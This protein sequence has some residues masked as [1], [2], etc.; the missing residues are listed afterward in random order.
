MFKA[1]LILATVL[2]L[3]GC[4]TTEV[5]LFYN[6]SAV[7]KPPIGVTPNSV[8]ILMVDDS[9]GTDPF[10]L[11]AI[12][13]GFGNPLKTLKTKQPVKEVVGKAFADGLRS[14]GLLAPSE[15]KIGMEVVI[16]KFHC[17]QYVRRKARVRVFVSLVKM[18]SNRQVYARD[19]KVDVV[20]GGDNIFDTGVIAKVE[21][22]SKV[23]NQAL[24]QVVEK[25]LDDRHFVSALKA[26]SLP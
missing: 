26:A 25:T 13:G 16:N 17:S 15:G 12:R 10:W 21:D 1:F 5:D 8:K 20:T 11:G 19:I 4:G 6:S 2:V 23:A 9:R 22:L 18:S 7:T 14:R 24:Q 3:S